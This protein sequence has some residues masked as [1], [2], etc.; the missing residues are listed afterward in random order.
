MARLA[1]LFHYTGFPLRESNVTTRLVLNELD[2]NLSSLAPRLVIVVVIVVSGSR[3]AWTLDA[4]SI[5]V[6]VASQ[7]VV[8]AG[9]VLSIGILDVGHSLIC[10]DGVLSAWL[11]VSMAELGMMLILGCGDYCVWLEI[12]D[13]VKCSSSR[14]GGKK[15]GWGKRAAE[16]EKGKGKKDNCELRDY[17]VDVHVGDEWAVTSETNKWSEVFRVFT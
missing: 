7:R 2:V 15:V 3:N 17:G 9:T 1:H 4:S 5:A 8:S 14:L 12:R 11:R 6:A 16:S 10:S 13:L